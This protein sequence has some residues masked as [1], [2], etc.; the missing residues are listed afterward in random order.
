MKLA[1]VAHKVETNI[2]SEEKTFSFSEKNAAKLALI[3]SSNLYSDKIGSII[4]ELCMNAYDAHVAAGTLD[5]PFKVVLPTQFQPTFTIEDYGTGLSYDDMLDLYTSYG[6]STKN[7]SNK[8]IGAFGLGS[9]SPFAYSS[10]FIVSS[11]YNGKKHAFQAYLNEQR[12]PTLKHLSTVDTLES[13]GLTIEIPVKQ[14]DFYSFNIKFNEFY[15]NFLYPIKNNSTKEKE[16][17]LNI[18]KDQIFYAKKSGDSVTFSDGI[19]FRTKWTIL[20]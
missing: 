19:F 4:R 3:L 12:M 18:V 14:N 8:F 1:T 5:K 2:Q 15:S 10:S 13:N 9:K 20:I 11:R 17:V 6:E 7:T 16:Y